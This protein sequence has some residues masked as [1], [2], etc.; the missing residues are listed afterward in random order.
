[1]LKTSSTSLSV[2]IPA[3]NE[4]TRLPLTMERSLDYLRSSQP[5]RDWDFIIVDDGSTDGTAAWAAAWAATQ[6]EQSQ[7]RVLRSRLNRGK[8]AALAAGAHVARGERLLFMDADGGTGLSLSA[9]P[10]LEETMD[11]TGCGVVVGRRDLAGHGRPW[12]RQL[13]GAV[14]RGL[15]STVVS[16]VADTQCGVK[17]LS[18]SAA[19]ATMP[20]LRVRRWAY[21]VEMVYLA[22][23]L[24]LGVASADVP[25]CDVPGSKVGLLTP[26]EMAFDVA[27]ISAF[28]R[29]GVWRLPPHAQAQRDQHREAVTNT[30]VEAPVGFEDVRI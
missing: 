8:G 12:H 11:R 5:E 13:M 3:L 17:L 9:L 20:H 4:R 2:I 26:V 28:Y 25:A 18:R 15:T 21:D 7:L 14:F 16:G 24:D 22:Q 1:M 30:A 23:R 10:R 6:N 19:A 27:C 29:L